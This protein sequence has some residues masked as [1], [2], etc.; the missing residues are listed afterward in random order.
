MDLGTGVLVLGLTGPHPEGKKPNI[1]IIWDD[2]IGWQCYRLS[3]QP[4]ARICDRHGELKHSAMG[5]AGYCPKSSTVLLDDASADRKPYAHALPLGGK[6]RREDL[7]H[8][9]GFKTNS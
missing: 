1:F 4:I 8:V 3:V 9:V 5:L 7:V 6:E 2:D